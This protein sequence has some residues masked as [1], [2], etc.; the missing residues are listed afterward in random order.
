MVCLA[1]LLAYS[2]L[3]IVYS[4]IPRQASD[5]QHIAAMTTFGASTRFLRMLAPSSLQLGL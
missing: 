3:N 4:L 1:H 2:V 5:T